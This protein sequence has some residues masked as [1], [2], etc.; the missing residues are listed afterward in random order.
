MNEK[1]LLYHLAPG[2]GQGGL[3]DIYLLKSI[4]FL[5]QSTY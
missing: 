2:V 4:T 3:R 1:A 5:N